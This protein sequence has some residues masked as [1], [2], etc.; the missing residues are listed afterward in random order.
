MDT[1]KIE[2]KEQLGVCGG[3]D[4]GSGKLRWSWK[5]GEWR[6]GSRMFMAL[7]RHSYTFV[8]LSELEW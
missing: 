8:G 2:K 7:W 5:A 4:A 3:L 6:I 1:W